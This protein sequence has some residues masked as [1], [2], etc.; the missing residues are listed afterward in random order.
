MHRALIACAK[1]T[2]NGMHTDVSCDAFFMLVLT[3]GT[4]SWAVTAWSRA[5]RKWDPLGLSFVP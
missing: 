1:D 2:M 5:G 3:L 4:P